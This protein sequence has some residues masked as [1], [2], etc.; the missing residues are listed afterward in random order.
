MN[1]KYKISANKKIKCLGCGKNIYSVTHFCKI[2]SPQWIDCSSKAHE[3][4]KRNVLYPN[5]EKILADCKIFRLVETK[6]EYEQF[7]DCPLAH[8]D[9][10]G[11]MY[12][13]LTEKPF[14]EKSIFEFIDEATVLT[15]AYLPR[16]RC[17]TPPGFWDLD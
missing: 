2:S 4:Y 11:V 15:E 3:R 12:I 9:R 6:Q 10:N 8:I 13:E 16:G 7:K 17:S 5:V 14:T 1:K